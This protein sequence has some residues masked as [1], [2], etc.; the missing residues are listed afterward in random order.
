MTDR[1]YTAVIGAMTATNVTEGAAATPANAIDLRV[2][3]DATGAN[4]QQVLN[5]L[6]AIRSYILQ[7][8]WPPV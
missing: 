2:T 7:D 8:T 6:E 1:Y 3:Y 5:G 4:K